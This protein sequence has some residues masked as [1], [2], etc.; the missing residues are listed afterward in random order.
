MFA[1]LCPT[2]VYMGTQSYAVSV[3]RHVSIHTVD[4]LHELSRFLDTYCSTLDIAVAQPNGESISFDIMMTTEGV[5]LTGLLSDDFCRST[6]SQFVSH[7]GTAL[8]FLTSHSVVHL[9]PCPQFVNWNQASQRFMLM[10]MHHVRRETNPVNSLAVLASNCHPL[11][12]AA[13][14]TAPLKVRPHNLS[15]TFDFNHTSTDPTKYVNDQI[16]VNVDK[17]VK[18][19]LPSVH[20]LEVYR[21]MCHENQSVM[22][23]V[24]SAVCQFPSNVH[25][26]VAGNEVR[27]L[28]D[29]EHVHW[30]IEA[31]ILNFAKIG[32][33]LN[34]DD[35]LVVDGVQR[36]LCQR[37]VE[38]VNGV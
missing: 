6:S 4:A 28:R 35:V 10:G 38:W 9:Q 14:V 19:V 16:V 15:G 1:F 23:N 34:R 30:E 22:A 8:S 12:A 5:P 27:P 21:L 13:V 33:A 18:I 24:N 36:L 11:Y 31:V 17:S 37:G 2:E 29:N 26:Y 32:L 7:M 25:V 20:M 3:I